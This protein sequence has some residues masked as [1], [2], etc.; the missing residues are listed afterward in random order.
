MKT[1]YAMLHIKQSFCIALH[2]RVYKIIA[3]NNS[4][5]VL[6]STEMYS[7]LKCRQ[8]CKK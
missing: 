4:R 2:K 1:I 8:N 7:S 5:S 6:Q 3:E